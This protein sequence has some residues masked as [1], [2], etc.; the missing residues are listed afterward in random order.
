[1]LSLEQVAHFVEHGFILLPLDELPA[2]F[3]SELYRKCER[4]WNEEG[5]RNGK[6]IFKEVPELNRVLTSR[7][8]Q[9]GLAS[10]LGED[11]TMHPA[12]HMHVS[13]DKDGGYHKD[14]GHCSIRH[15]RP[16]WAMAMY[17]AGGCT[18]DMGPTS[19]IPG[20]SRRAV[21]STA[22]SACKRNYLALHMPACWPKIECCCSF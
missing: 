3:H 13:A 14:G 9:G 16:R 2:S 21:P 8:L 7:T 5:G 15:H 18:V 6:D 17:Y 12:R 4:R 1:M 11:Y 20:V 22:T 10:V 19:V